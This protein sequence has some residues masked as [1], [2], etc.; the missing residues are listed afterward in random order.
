MQN[1]TKDQDSCRPAQQLPSNSQVVLAS[2]KK[3][4]WPLF[5]LSDPFLLLSSPLTTTLFSTPLPM[6]PINLTLY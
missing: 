6:L 3:N 5:P 4:C 1:D 2:Y